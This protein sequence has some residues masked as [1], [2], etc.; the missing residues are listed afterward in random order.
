MLIMLINDFHIN[1]FKKLNDLTSDFFLSLDVP[2]VI[3]TPWMS[4]D[5][6]SVNLCK[7]ICQNCK[8]FVHSKWILAWARAHTCSNNTSAV[9]INFS[10]NLISFHLIK[11]LNLISF[12]SVWTGTLLILWQ[13]YAFTFLQHNVTSIKSCCCD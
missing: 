4:L 2:V 6:L 7:S 3:F 10:L 11:C 1:L 9:M 13:I 8:L 5:F 12:L